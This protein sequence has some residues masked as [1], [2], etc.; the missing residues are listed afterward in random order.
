[1]PLFSCRLAWPLHFPGALVHAQAS[2]AHPGLIYVVQELL[3]PD[4]ANVSTLAAVALL[5]INVSLAGEVTV[6]LD[7]LISSTA[8]PES[9][10]E[11][12][13]IR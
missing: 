5:A 13:H 11:Y 1:M 8:L 10:P 6:S 9:L 7:R 2:P 4:A 3:L 12:S